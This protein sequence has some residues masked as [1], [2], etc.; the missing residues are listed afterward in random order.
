MF[1]SL[2]NHTQYSNLKLRDSTNRIPDMVKRAI[3]YGFTSI[4][5]TD[6][7]VLSGHM[8]ALEVGDTIREEHP[9]FKIILGNEIYLIRADE[10]KNAEKYW[11]FILLA[12]SKAG[13]KILRQLSTRA[14]ERSYV[15]R[16]QRRCPTFFE[17]LEE[18]V[19]PNQGEIIAST[20]CL[21]G[22]LPNRILSHN[23]Q[24]AGRFLARCVDIFGKDNFFLEMQDSD[25]EEQQIVNR[26]IIKISA[27]TGIPYIITQDAHYD[28][29]ESLPIFSAFLNSKE[30][31]DREVGA[32]YKYTYMKTEDEMKQILSYLPPEDVQRGIDNT[33]I[34]H[35]RI[36]RYD[37][38]SDTLVPKRKLPEFEV[39]HVFK[40]WYDKYPF[41]KQYAY[42]EDPQD[43]FLMYLI[44]Q[45][46][47]DKNLTLDEAHIERINKELDILSYS[48]NNLGQPLSSYLNLVQE[49][50]QLAWQVSF[51]GCGRGSAPAWLVN[52]LI[53]ITDFDPMPFN[54][55]EWRFLNKATI[56]TLTEEE[57]KE[58]AEGKRP[59]LSVAS[60]MMD[61]DNDYAGTKSNEI[62]EIT[63]EHYGRDRVLNT[64]TYKRESLKSAIQTA[65]RGLG[66]SSDES[67][68]ISAMVP[69]SRGHVYTLQECEGGDEEKGFEAAPRV[70]DALK[71]HTDLYETVAK[72]ENLISG[73]GVHAS[74][75][76]IGAEP[77]IEH[78]SMM[79]APNG[80]PITCYDY[81]GCDKASLLKVDYLYTDIQSRLMKCMELMLKGG[82][83]EW[84]GSLRETY[85]KYF[86]PDVLEYDDP[87]IYEAMY[88]GEVVG[89]FQFDSPTGSVCI[90]RTKPMSVKQLSAANAVMRLMG[91][92]GQ[93]TP[94]DRYV[95][96]RNDINE[97]YKEMDEWGLTEDEQQ[98]L[99]DVVGDS[100]GIGP[101]QEDF[102]TLL[103]HPKVTNFSQ[104]EC[105]WARKSVSKK[106][107]KEI[108]KLKK[109]FFETADKEGGPRKEFL[110]YIF[111]NIISQQLG[112]SF[113]APHDCSYS[114][115]ALQEANIATRY[116][117]LYWRCACLSVDSGSSDTNMV[118]D[119]GDEEEVEV[120]VDEVV[121]EQQRKEKESTPDYGKISKAVA[122][123][124]L[125]G[126][127]I[128]PGDVNLAELDYYP[129]TEH[130]TIILSLKAITGVNTEFATRI[131]DNRPYTSLSDFISKVNPSTLQMINLIKAGSF[132]SLYP[133]INRAAIMEEYLNIYADQNVSRKEKLTMANFEKLV[134][135]GA[136]P[137]T[138]D[139]A[140]RV[141]V[142]K[143]LVDTNELDKANKRYCL[144][145]E[146]SLKFFNKYFKMRLTLGKQYDIIPEGIAV[147]QSAF[148]KVCDDYCAEVKEWMNSEE[149]INTFYRAEF[150]FK[151]NELR[152][153]YCQG[154][155]S[156]WEMQTVHYYGHDHELAHVNQAK[157]DISNFENLPEIPVPIGEKQNREGNT[158]PIYDVKTIVGTVINVDN[159][160]H[161]V[162]LLTNFGTVVDVK[163]YSGQFINLYKTISV[164]EPNGKKR[165][166]EKPWLQRGNLLLVNGFRRENSF[167][168]RSDWAHGKRHSVRLI[169]QVVGDDLILKDEREE[170]PEEYKKR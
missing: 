78:I 138:H 161:I 105:N 26:A 103:K 114:I 137:Q 127:S 64:L 159:M 119:Y 74:A 25:S 134:N 153:K 35:N 21:G 23:T 72:V 53:G 49:I 48:S 150:E 61:I 142:F 146:A 11:H 22:Y 167:V 4:A 54:L 20:A 50:V 55:P 75:V 156:K 29:A 58:V 81:R 109:K 5:I 45:G 113:S 69:M 86:H 101:E 27:Q 154:S 157:Y 83:I 46:V 141:M 19:K 43:R 51:V 135:M 136:L 129:D 15:E 97:W 155:V 110:E 10:Y 107:L 17:D 44:E 144:K 79:R 145:S 92:E 38:R 168:P 96:F 65:C 37:L 163:F 80:T 76:Y 36:Q 24:E 52:Y 122:M 95:R 151:K 62:M 125:S 71:S 148:K 73:A 93:E 67:R 166:I 120:Q 170:I 66:I 91:Q 32:F 98:V 139:F 87:T 118:E 6:H 164:I 140:R 133:D 94:L 130:N 68:E 90:K 7:E 121:A 31:G 147:K 56:P 12:T 132:D 57:K 18:L 63:K 149:G 126:T 88:L 116:N 33:Q 1:S 8:E 47:K 123:A 9:D 152:E 117:P 104:A 77:Y 124:K 112:Y 128:S 99:K 115:E 30:E 2:H 100:F 14:W 60:Y 70:I 165:V 131:M 82:A 16:G 34:I 84:Q 41:I 85:K 143:K 160:K 42:A 39:G 106:K 108:E 28:V 13:H 89:L 169:T 59:P 162:T 111:R 102:M 158:I 3:S 40:E